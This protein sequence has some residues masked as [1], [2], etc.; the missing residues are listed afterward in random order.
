MSLVCVIFLSLYLNRYQI[1][2]NPNAI[3]QLPGTR[4]ALHTPCSPRIK[5]ALTK[6][7]RCSLFVGIRFGLD[8]RRHFWHDEMERGW[9]RESENER[10]GE[11]RWE[12]KDKEPNRNPV[13]EKEER[14]GGESNQNRK[15]EPSGDRDGRQERVE[16]E[17]KKGEHLSVSQVHFDAWIQT[18]E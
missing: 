6:C 12:Q 13:N 5:L 17:E 1:C 14:W 10:W 7:H 3:G 8:L 18:G 2:T 15:A 4:T 11:K 16:E 9:E